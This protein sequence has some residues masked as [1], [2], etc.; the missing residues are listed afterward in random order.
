MPRIPSHLPVSL[1]LPLLAGTTVVCILVCILSLL[2]GYTIIFQNLL[3]IP[4]IIACIFY[5]T[6]GFFF[7]CL[8][9]LSYLLLIILIAHSPEVTLQA[10]IRVIIFVAIAGVI[11][12]LTKAWHRAEEQLQGSEQELQIQLKE[13]RVAQEKLRA[14][15]ER[16]SDLFTRIQNAIVVY[17]A[18]DD[19]RD[20][21]IVD[22]NPA[23][24]EIEQ[25][26]RDDVIGR[27]VT[28][29]FP[30]VDDFGLLSV[31]KRVFES[32]I[33]EHHDISFYQDNRIQGWRENLVYRLSSG[34][35]VAIYADVT[36]RRQREALIKKTNAYLEGL[37]SI[38]NVPIII[39]DQ[40]FHITR[41]NYACEQ[42]I[43]R[44]AEDV[45]G[46]SIETLFPPSE[47]DRLMRLL[48]TT[49]DGVRWETTQIDIQHRDGSIRN[50][51]WNSATLYTTDGGSPIATIAQGRDVTGELR[52]EQ[53]KDAVLVQIQKNL[54][55]LAILNDEIRN[56]LTII[57]SCADLFGE[58]GVVRRIE[59]QIKRIDEIVSHLDTRWMES[60]KV[61][62]AI[63]NRYHVY[64]S[65][66]GEAGG[67]SDLPAV[68]TDQQVEDQTILIEEIQAELYTILDSIDAFVYVADMETYELIYLNR[69]A[70]SLFGDHAGSKCYATIYKDMDG[71]CPFCTNTHLVDEAGP[72]GVY[73]WE[74]QNTHTGRWYDCRDRAIRW[75]G[76]RMVRLE[77]AT[78]ITER[79]RT[80]EA[81]RETI[82]ELRQ[83]NT[84][85]IGR[86]V[87]MTELKSEI[88]TLLRETG[89]AEKYRID[90]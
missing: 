2:A 52:L 50:V 17:R 72:T 53:E 23:G 75:T 32:G 22:I 48:Q 18:I 65:P 6:R 12:L 30:G 27:R 81:L 47:K 76:G 8:L 15:E 51:L 62:N 59:D 10:G 16:W 13:V 70:R 74:V 29:V 3:Y 40:D 35:V 21:V 1:P 79:K 37:I 68:S 5:R 26:N 25:V 38:A 39:W 42:L 58:P 82:E 56:P 33:P 64:V 63:R 31:M 7:S 41:I 57:L 43:G 24:A 28:A 44:T 11:T 36:E 89:R 60:E 67:S 45:T 86:E 19:G 78:D 83:F 49:L 55:Q 20:F 61:L 88:N 87:R 73:K 34:E 80:E 66:A 85:T 71:P 90:P 46:S 4:I 9:A 77:I 69:K 84:L 14:S 54:A